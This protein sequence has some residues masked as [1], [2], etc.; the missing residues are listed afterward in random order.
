MG[1]IASK[2]NSSPKWTNFYDS[3]G[4]RVAVEKLTPARESDRSSFKLKGEELIVGMVC[5]WGIWDREVYGENIRGTVVESQSD[6]EIIKLKLK[7]KDNLNLDPQFQADGEYT[8]NLTR[9]DTKLEGT[10]QGLYRNY[11]VQGRVVGYLH[12]PA[13]TV[14]L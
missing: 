10:F 8:L 7:L 12:R 6:G 13:A 3:S 2:Y 14:N 11:S 9:D 5:R 1:P 4:G